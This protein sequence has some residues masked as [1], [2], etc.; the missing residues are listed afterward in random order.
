MLTFDNPKYCITNEKHHIFNSEQ[1]NTAFIQLLFEFEDFG[2]LLAEEIT[3][4]FAGKE[5]YLD[6][7]FAAQPPTLQV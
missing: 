3:K 2:Q 7:V 5:Q 1:L 4:V 6:E